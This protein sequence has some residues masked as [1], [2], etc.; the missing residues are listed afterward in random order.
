MLQKDPEG[1]YDAVQRFS[2]VHI[3]WEITFTYPF[4]KIKICIYF[5]QL[6]NYIS[7]ANF[8]IYKLLSKI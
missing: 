6:L 5:I 4:K 2:D 1:T 7:L 3:V 8:K